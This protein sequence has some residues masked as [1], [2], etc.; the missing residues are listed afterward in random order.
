[1][2]F[3]VIFTL[4][5]NKLNGKKEG[6]ATDS[7][8]LSIMAPE[9]VYILKHLVEDLRRIANIGEDPLKGFK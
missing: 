4:V 8:C 1:V 6:Q 7:S 3:S 5:N 9:P 2:S